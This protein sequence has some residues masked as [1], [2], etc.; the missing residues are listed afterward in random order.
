MNRYL[1]T[2]LLAIAAA[3]ISTGASAT[4]LAGD[5]SIESTP[6]VSTLSRAQVQAELRQ[7]KASGV[8]PWALNYNQL[9]VFHGT[10]T[11][12]QVVSEFLQSRDEAAAM[13]AEDSGSA[14]LSA[15]GRTTAAPVLAGQPV[16]A[17]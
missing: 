6:F 1:I 8:N 10:N 9:A 14:Y 2:S 13:T 17:Q 16:N 3:G 4:A 7:F 15:H 5:I 12:A 11:R